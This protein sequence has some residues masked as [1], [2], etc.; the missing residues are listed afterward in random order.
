[1]NVPLR[2]TSFPLRLLLLFCFWTSSEPSLCSSQ[3]PFM[4]YFFSTSS[5]FPI[6]QLFIL[7]LAPL[8][9]FNSDLLALLKNSR[10]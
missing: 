3:S 5:I 8:V 9:L 6:P 10:K 4:I 2:M 7:S 1:M